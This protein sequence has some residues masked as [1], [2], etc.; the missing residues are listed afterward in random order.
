[1]SKSKIKDTLSGIRSILHI[2]DK[3]GQHGGTEEYITSLA[4]QLSPMGISSH[5]IFGNPHRSISPYIASHKRIA[6][7]SSNDDGE[8][9]Y[10]D[11]LETI[12]TI[13]PDIVYV[14]NIFNEQ[15]I[16]ILDM[17]ARDYLILWYIH[18]HYL[19][20][21]TELRALKNSF[22]SICY[23]PLSKQCVSNIRMGYCIKRYTD[24]IYTYNDL[25]SRQNLLKSA[26]LVDAVIVVSDFMK[27]ILVNNLPDIKSRIHV[28]PRQ[29]RPVIKTVYRKNN[30]NNKVYKWVVA[31]S[32]RITR[33]KGLHVAIKAISMMHLKEKILFKIAGPIENEKY[34]SYCQKLARKAEANNPQLKFNY[35][36]HLSYNDNDLF[37]ADSDVVVVPSIWGEPLGIVAAESLSNG[38]AVIASKA[39]GID[40]LIK[41][42]KTGLLVEP[43]NVAALSQG[44]K[45]LLFNET[46]RK[47]LVLSGRRLIANK[48][49][50]IEHLKALEKVILNCRNGTKISH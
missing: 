45:K 4:L 37:F 6:G 11:L 19:S 10:Q 44:L 29:I 8:N 39:G 13:N 21:L 14:H 33:E 50:A 9:I 38:T 27:D 3:A 36:G 25:F 47:K 26:R 5:L 17:P 16:K 35:E 48:F 30:K 1:M 23:E 34:W 40:T 24:K 32:G 2:N 43:N 20:C 31:Y 49:N 12:L 41:H 28:L 22:K 46:L 42:E 15:I 7:I 18:D